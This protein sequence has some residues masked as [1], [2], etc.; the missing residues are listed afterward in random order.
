MTRPPERLEIA[1]PIYREIIPRKLTLVTRYNLEPRFQTA[2]DLL[3]DGRLDMNGLLTAFQS[4][5]R[6]NAG[7]RVER[8]DYRE[9]DRC[10]AQKGHWIL[11]DRTPDKPWEE[12]IFRQKEAMGRKRI[13]IWGM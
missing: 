4:F 6:E 7:H 13:E 5:F 1:N 9:A 8:F 11:F 3:S 10:G 2:W 12:K